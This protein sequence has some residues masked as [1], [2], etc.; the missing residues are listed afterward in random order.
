MTLQDLF[1]KLDGIFHF[2]LDVAASLDDRKCWHYIDEHIDGR[3]SPWH[4]RCIWCNPPH[5]PKDLTIWAKR[6]AQHGAEGRIAAMI[7]PAADLPTR[8]AIAQ[9]LFAD[10]TLIYYPQEI[11]EGYD[12]PVMI[13]FFG[14]VKSSQRD[15]LCKLAGTVQG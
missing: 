4:G 3:V 12:S 6:C 2:D 14:P 9:Y 7:L 13:G 10:A 11:L 15:A 1:D 8:T 5:D